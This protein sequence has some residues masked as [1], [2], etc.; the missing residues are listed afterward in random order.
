MSYNPKTVSPDFRHFMRDRYPRLDD[1]PVYWRL[2]GHIL[3]SAMTDETTDKVLLPRDLL[4]AIEGKEQLLASH[5][6]TAEVL[7]ERFSHHI[8]PIIV[9]PWRYTDGL[10][11]TIENDVF[12]PDVLEAAAVERRQLARPD[13]VDFATGRPFTR[14][15]QAR[16][17]Q[18]A[19]TA[20]NLRRSTAPNAVTGMLL[21]YMNSRPSHGFTVLRDY[22]PDAMAAAA[23]IEDE[24]LRRRQQNLLRAIDDQPQPFYM[25][26]D[27]SARINGSNESVLR[28]TRKI[29]KMLTRGWVSFDLR[30][31]QLAI[32]AAEWQVKEVLHFLETRRSIWDELLTF[33]G[34]DLDPGLKDVF[35]PMLYG[36]TF[37][38]ANKGIFRIFDKA[39][40]SR[41]QA[42]YLMTHPLMQAMFEAR[43]K[44]LQE[45]IDAGGAEDCFGTW[46][47]IPWM[48]Y[49]KGS[50]PVWR[51]NPRSVL[52]QLAQSRE[53]QL[54]LPILELA[55]QTRQFSIMLWLHD[56][57]SIAFR[58]ATRTKLWSG[59]IVEA[60]NRQATALGI[61]TELLRDEG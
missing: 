42:R 8:A 16:M 57:C 21:D 9:T 20:A 29:R 22:L 6:Y 3:F 23:Q 52:A 44:R 51:P 45:I 10:A 13:R 32:C 61:P 7:L 33:F 38:A 28:C 15:A 39:G 48:N 27:H 17:R 4:A 34:K 14:Q 12:A 25:P 5:R 50:R 43:E 40:R 53:L 37:G 59:R 58:D 11:R 24:L 35:K 41:D 60:V 47:S 1:D 2:A 56:G 49:G 46:I 54:M 55:Q 26:S 30:S 36:V 19:R 31:A 18:E